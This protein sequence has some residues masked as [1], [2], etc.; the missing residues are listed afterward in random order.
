MLLAG[1]VAGISAVQAQPPVPHGPGKPG[2]PATENRSRPAEGLV[3][4][5]TLNGT[6]GEFTTNDEA[7]L[8]GFTLNTGSATTTVQFPAHL[9]KAIQSAGKTGSN[10]TITGL[11]EVTPEG[12]SVFRLYNLTSGGTTV[13]DTPPSLP[14][15]PATPQAIT[16]KGKVLD[17]L[18]D[19]QGQINGLQLS[20]QT[21]VHVPPHI[22]SQIRD[23]V[24]KAS[25]VSVD[26]FVKP[27]G[28]GQ[29]R[30]RKLTVVEA[31][32]ISANGKSFLMR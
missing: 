6:I 25:E 14:L 17:Y 11:N 9:G 8:N 31:S 26:G 5:T 19:K 16:V 24:P 13:A 10:V 3:A 27:L 20:D 7:I 28:E 15:T 2:R 29:I 18:F 1:I 32:L 23:I 12:V 30:L 4:L 21:I 22:G